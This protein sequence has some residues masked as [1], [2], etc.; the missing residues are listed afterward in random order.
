MIVIRKKKKKETEQQKK[1]VE[2]TNEE[3]FDPFFSLSLFPVKRQTDRYVCMYTV[4]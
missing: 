4:E 1:N 3:N 2:E